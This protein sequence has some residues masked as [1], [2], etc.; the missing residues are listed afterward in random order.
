MSTNSLQENIKHLELPHVAAAG[1]RV[2]W[3]QRRR[4]CRRAGTRGRHHPHRMDDGRR[5]SSRDRAWRCW[6]I[7]ISQSEKTSFTFHPLP[8]RR[9]GTQLIGRK[10]LASK[11]VNRLSQ[12]IYEQSYAYLLRY[13]VPFVGNASRKKS[14]PKINSAELVIQALQTNE[15]FVNVFLGDTFWGDKK[16]HLLSER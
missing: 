2:L 5:T 16:N 9:T 15:Y 11:I 12:K 7:R 6:K 8:G 1:T 14:H 13:C 10:A 4:R 3:H